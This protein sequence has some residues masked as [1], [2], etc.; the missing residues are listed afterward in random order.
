[1]QSVYY[2]NHEGAAPSNPLCLAEVR[3]VRVTAVLLLR[4]HAYYS[5]AEAGFLVGEVKLEVVLD[6]KSTVSQMET[7]GRQYSF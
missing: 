5:L 6:M 7:V 2:S 4:S 3:T 1:M